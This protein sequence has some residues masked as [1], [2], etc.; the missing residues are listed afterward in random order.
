MIIKT[1]LLSATFIGCISITPAMSADMNALK[2]EAVGTIK[3]FGGAL[4]GELQKAMK[5]GG[6]V[7]ALGACNTEAPKIAA[8]MS[9]PKGWTVSRTSLKYRNPGN[10]PDA[11]EL[12]TLKMFEAKKAAGTPVS[13]LARA[14]IVELDGAKVYRLVKAI[15]TGGVCLNCHG[16]KLKPEV[17][18][19][20][21][22]LYP[23]DMAQGFKVG[24][25]RGAFS[26]Y[27]PL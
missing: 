11:F 24:D 8:Q 19:K 9:S 3:K 17:L 4:K 21:N 5:A 23:G 26:V 15:P 7:K 20:I 18:Q 12:E 13:K 1:A 25:I 6:P 14:E 27:K 10:R 2:A 16:S 22:A